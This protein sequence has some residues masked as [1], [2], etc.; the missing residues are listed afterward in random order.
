MNRIPAFSPQ[1]GSER[2]ISVHVLSTAA[3]F[4][5]GRNIENTRYFKGFAGAAGDNR[6]HDPT[7]T[8]GVL[9]H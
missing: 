6:N 8:K 4:G 5:T 3:I 7:L 2:G 1:Q 9:Y